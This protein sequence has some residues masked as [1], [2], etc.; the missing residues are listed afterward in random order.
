LPAGSVALPLIAPLPLTLPLTV[1]PGQEAPLLAVQ[2]QLVNV[3]PAGTA[4]ATAAVAS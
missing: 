1:P 4:S 3:R 2:V